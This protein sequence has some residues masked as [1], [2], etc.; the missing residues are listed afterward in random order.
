MW[1][2]GQM[3]GFGPSSPWQKPTK[4]YP[5]AGSVPQCGC[6]PGQLWHVMVSDIKWP[7]TLSMW[8]QLS[9]MCI[10]IYMYVYV[11]VYIYTH[12]LGTSG[13][14]TMICRCN[15]KKLTNNMIYGSLW[16]WGTPQNCHF[17]KEISCWSNKKLDTLCSD[18][19]I[20]PPPIWICIF[21]YVRKIHWKI[22]K[23]HP[24]PKSSCPP[25]ELHTT[26]GCQQHC[27]DVGVGRH[28]STSPSSSSS[29]SSLS[30]PL[31]DW[32]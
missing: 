4:A 3:S 15:A 6:S 24:W 17:E 2:H 10:Y 1:N 12:I 7:M 5:P 30:S 21:A 8:Y 31:H 19:P 18:K 23:D 13:K 9:F 26:M 29:S 16:K 28:P 25:T 20:L 22:T 11:R 27:S 32:S 14:P